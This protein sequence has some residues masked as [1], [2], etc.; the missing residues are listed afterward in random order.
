MQGHQL[1][2]GC[3]NTSP[4]NLAPYPC[5]SLFTTLPFWWPKPTKIFL[6]RKKLRKW[7]T[8]LLI[9][10]SEGQAETDGGWSTLSL[11]T[12]GTIP[13][14]LLVYSFNKYLF[15]LS[16]HCWERK[17]SAKMSEAQK[18]IQAA[19]CNLRHTNDQLNVSST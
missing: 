15:P 1:L 9:S 4:E 11:R 13:M 12:Q 2:S 8:T 6:F 16:R 10:S 14:F 3:G 7:L 5:L 19:R 17:A 18:Q